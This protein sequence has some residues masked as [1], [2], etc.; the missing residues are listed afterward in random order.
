[1]LVRPLLWLLG[2]DPDSPGRNYPHSS[3][4]GKKKYFIK[5]G[6]EPPS[7]SR[8]KSTLLHVSVLIIIGYYTEILCKKWKKLLFVL[9]LNFN[10]VFMVFCKRLNKLVYVE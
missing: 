6:H 3:I 4:A 5:V 10:L 1:M 8:W 9:G 2:R 7:I